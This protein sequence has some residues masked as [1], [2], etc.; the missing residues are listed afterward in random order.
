MPNYYSIIDYIPYAVCYISVAYLFYNWKF[1]PLNPL[2]TFHPP[3]LET[4]NVF[5]VPII[6]LFLF[7]FVRF[8]HST[9]R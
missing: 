3:T 1:V 2:H 5:S 9:C 6:S 7:C 8:I 4:T